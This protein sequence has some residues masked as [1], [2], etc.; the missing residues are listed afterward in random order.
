MNF[1]RHFLSV[2]HIKSITLSLT[3]LVSAACSDSL[4]SEQG[5]DFKD[6]QSAPEV[7]T[8]FDQLALINGLTTKV[9]LPSIEQFKQDTTTLTADINNY[10][11]SV[12]ASNSAS[13]QAVEELAIAQNSWRNTMDT[14]Q[15][16]EVMQVG[17]LIENDYNLRN[18]I[19]SWPLVNYCAVDQDVGHNEVGQFNG[20][21]YDISRRTSN[22]KG[23]TTIEYLLFNDSLAHACSKDSLAPTGWNERPAEERI[24][25]RCEFA[26]AVANDLNQNATLLHT[27]WTDE[28]NGFQ[29]QLL[30]S[31]QSDSSFASPHKAINA[32]TD[33]MFYIDSI[34]KD[35]K[36]GAP[37]G[38]ADNSCGNMACVADVESN[39]ADYGLANIRNNLVAFRMLFVGGSDAPEDIGFDDF[40]REV[41]GDELATTM[42]NDIDAAITLIEQFNEAADTQVSN[43][44]ATAINGNMND[45]VTT[46]PEKIQA[47][48]VAVKKVTDN[49]KSLFITYLALELPITSAGD[50][51]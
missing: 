49:L 9:F 48:Y 22:R 18:V 7:E 34:T 27:N 2:P 37:I 47:V 44:P 13:A 43:Q 40:L 41:D 10:C 38:L 14:W 17:P 32:L 19:Y 51:D 8:E 30:T 50:A 46:N 24:K 11:S 26:T 6:G 23:L 29:S 1:S 39:I 31:G 45:A 5:A 25:A 33:A 12:D 21:D 28:T 20:E 4:T 36:L 42:T 35:S 3:L 15:K 16:I